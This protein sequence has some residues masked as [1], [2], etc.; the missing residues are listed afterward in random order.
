MERDTRQT[1]ID[2]CLACH[3]VCLDLAADIELAHGVEADEVVTLMADCAEICF[4]VA[5]SLSE[6]PSGINRAL[7]RLCAELC[8]RCAVACRREARGRKAEECVLACRRCSESCADMSL[9]TRLQ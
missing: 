2:R 3:M 7:A 9:E 1:C 5:S 6:R 8:G 4:L